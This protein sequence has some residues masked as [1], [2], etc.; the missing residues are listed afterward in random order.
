MRRK[1]EGGEK[2]GRDGE[3]TLKCSQRSLRTPSFPTLAF[4][5][6][7]GFHLCCCS[8]EKEALALTSHREAVLPEEADGVF[9]PT[10]CRGANSHLP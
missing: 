8:R 3:C 9:L 10:Q 1:R 7:N 2:R 4:G 6:G 5:G